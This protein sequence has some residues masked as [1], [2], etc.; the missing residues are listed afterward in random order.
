MSDPC[1]IST[2]LRHQIMVSM[3]QMDKWI[4]CA[5]ATR[6]GGYINPPLP[7]SDPCAISTALRHQI[8]VSMNQ[9]DKWGC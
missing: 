2:A 4:D 9:M 5:D 6:S 3:N 1:A 7:M 8:M